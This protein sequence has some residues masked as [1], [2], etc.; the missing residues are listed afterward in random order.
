MRR[1]VLELGDPHRVAEILAGARL[2]PRPALRQTLVA[3]RTPLESKLAT[4]ASEC[5]RVAPVGVDDDF[6][7][8]GGDS[9]IGTLLLSRI[10]EASGVALELRAIFDAPT[11][12]KLAEAI[13]RI[14]LAAV[15]DGDLSAAIA[16]LDGLSDEEVRALLTQGGLVG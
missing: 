11:V 3:P 2:R 14:Q 8:L 7:E 4:L 15:D 6:F 12:A 10:R 13:E 5:L 1:I 16:A 9:L